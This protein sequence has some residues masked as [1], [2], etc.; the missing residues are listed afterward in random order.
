M[1]SPVLCIVLQ[2]RVQG[3]YS[4]TLS[5]F[6]VKFKTVEDVKTVIDSK[7]ERRAENCPKQC[8]KMLENLRACQP[9]FEDP[10][11]K[12]TMIYWPC[13]RPVLLINY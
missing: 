9:A 6:S 12:K 1:L 7:F 10:K 2:A 13:Y 3:R 8:C 5:L 11:R 4:V